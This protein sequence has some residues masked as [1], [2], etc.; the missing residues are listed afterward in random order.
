MAIAEDVKSRAGP[1]EGPTEEE[2]VKRLPMTLRVNSRTAKLQAPWGTLSNHCA[3]APRVSILKLRGLISW[4]KVS[5][6]LVE[7]ACC[8]MVFMVF[9]GCIIVCA[10]ERDMAPHIMAS[11]KCRGRVYSDACGRFPSLFSIFNGLEEDALEEDALEEDGLVEG[12]V[13]VFEAIFVVVFVRDDVF[14]VVYLSF[15]LFV[16]VCVVCVA[17]SMV[18]V[19][20]C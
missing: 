15:L 18:C 17:V 1:R 13:A 12:G 8:R 14:I 20:V 11:A 5:F 10:V 9:A 19:F 6:A 2:L 7:G 16:C 4:E 3:P